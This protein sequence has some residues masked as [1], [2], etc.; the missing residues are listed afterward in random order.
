[1]KGVYEQ[2]KRKKDKKKKKKQS[3][4]RYMVSGSLCLTSFINVEFEIS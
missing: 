2:K 4:K 3:Q 1:M